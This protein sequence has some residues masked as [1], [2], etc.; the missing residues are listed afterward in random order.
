MYRA[1]P[2]SFNQAQSCLIEVLYYF[3]AA[4]FLGSWKELFTN[5]L[6]QCMHIYVEP[7]N[8]SLPTP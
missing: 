1:V 3:I 7:L 8:I 5:S 6:C 2:N 4:F